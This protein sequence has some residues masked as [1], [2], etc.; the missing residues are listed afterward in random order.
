MT[1][2]IEASGRL[3][4]DNSH[5]FKTSLD[6]T[7]R[8]NKQ[9]NQTKKQKKYLFT[10]DQIDFVNT[11]D[12]QWHILQWWKWPLCAVPNGV[13]NSHMGILGF[14]CDYADR[15][16]EY[17]LFCSFSAMHNWGSTILYE[18]FQECLTQDFLLYTILNSMMKLH[19]WSRPVLSLSR[20]CTLFIM[21]THSSSQSYL[22]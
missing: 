14:I 1:S 13:S 15:E 9:K 3:R 21:F 8:P 20:V 4:Q 5:K 11:S 7:M 18:K 17:F 22:L 10:L 2:V 19:V 6:N 12:V 16:N